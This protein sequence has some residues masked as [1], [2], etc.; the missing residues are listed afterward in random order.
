MVIPGIQVMNVI[1]SPWWP[2]QWEGPDTPPLVFPRRDLVHV[3]S[4]VYAVRYFL[5]K[6]SLFMQILSYEE[7]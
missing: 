1:N 5:R 7:I 2:V 4:M 3:V 6:D